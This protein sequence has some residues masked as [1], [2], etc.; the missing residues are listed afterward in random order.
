MPIKYLLL[1][2]M[3][4]IGTMAGAQTK[5]EKTIPVKAGQ[6]LVLDL[7]YPEAKIQTWD[8]ADV[9]ITGTVSI[10]Q[11]EHDSAFQ[12]EVMTTGNK[13]VVTSLIK[14]KESLPKRLLIKKGDREYY[15]K[16]DNYHDPDVQKFLAE[17]GNEYS[18]RSTGIHQEIHLT[19]FVPRNTPVEVNAKYGLVEV[20][21]FEGPLTANSKYGGMDITFPLQFKGR[22]TASCQ[23]GEIYTNLEASFDRSM[24]DG[25]NGKRW[26][27]ISARLGDGPAFAIESKYGNIYLRKSK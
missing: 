8:K 13:L 16:T 5:I 14:D 24:N 2:G 10:N 21:S 22:I 7:D 27:A 20:T 18:Y 4:A 17:N 15:F 3:I 26:T 6:T 19:V 11:G 12:L 1:V 23:Y 25:K 9:L